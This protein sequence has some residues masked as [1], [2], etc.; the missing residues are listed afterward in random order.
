MRRSARRFINHVRVERSMSPSTVESYR[1]DLKKFIEF[2]ERRRRKDLLPGDVTPEMIHEFLDFLGNEDTGRRI[3][4]H[5]DPN[6]S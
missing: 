1:D 2:I 6:V 4:H 3:G 5:P